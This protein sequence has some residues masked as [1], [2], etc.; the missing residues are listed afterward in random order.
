MNKKDLFLKI[1][2]P[3]IAVILTATI[4]FIIYFVPKFDKTQLTVKAED[5][6]M[7]I[8]EEKTLN[9]DVSIKDAVVSFKIENQY[10]LTS[11]NFNIKAINAG[12]TSITI[13]ATYKDQFASCVCNVTVLT[14]S[15]EQNSEQPETPSP[16]QPEDQNPS[17]EPTTPEEPNDTPSNIDF[18]IYNQSGCRIDGNKIS[19]T[20]GNACYFRISFSS[21]VEYALN[22]Q[23]GI[24]VENLKM[25][26][27]T[28]KLTA[29]NA[30]T[31]QILVEEKIVGIIEVLI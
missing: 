26:N 16:E 17:Q 7:K 14:S 22:A 10:I 25:G 21:E 20:Q 23:N 27:N 18:Q 24:Q 28:F 3:C 4:F 13:K 12:T 8:N 1:I 29:S 9:F 11:E 6:S 30:G 31:I 15:Q 19:V 2:L 5:I